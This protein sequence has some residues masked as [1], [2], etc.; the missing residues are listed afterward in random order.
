MSELN[1]RFRISK[2]YLRKYSINCLCIGFP[3]R[4]VSVFLSSDNAKYLAS[5]L[6]NNKTI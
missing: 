5:K 1:F 2:T 6:F 4:P 3:I